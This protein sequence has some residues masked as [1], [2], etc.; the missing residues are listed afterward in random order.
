MLQKGYTLIEILVSL[1]I[2][3]FLSG[4]ALFVYM[5][6]SHSYS[7]ILNINHLEEQIRS[8]MYKMVQ[9]VSRAGYSA[10]A[11][12]DM[13]TGENTNQFMAAGSDLSIPNSSCILLTYDSDSTGALPALNT[14][15]Y[16]KRYGFRL[17]EGKLQ[18]RPLTDSTFSCT[19]GAW[20]DLT[21][22]NIV[23]VTNLTFTPNNV[24][25]AIDGTSTLLIR[26]VT[27]SITATLSD[28][29][30]ISRTMTQT[31]RVRNDKFQP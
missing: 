17:F 24:T 25:V 20:Q 4:I 11:I 18:S 21:D 1:G 19:S 13:G 14:A 8:A 22:S 29:S 2:S 30:T 28:D 3:L 9:D 6:I 5:A 15:N 27:I 10:A 16:D 31:V 23:N 26:N 7:E 12:N